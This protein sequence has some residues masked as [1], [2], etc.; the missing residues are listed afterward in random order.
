MFIPDSCGYLLTTHFLGGF[1]YRFGR[2]KV[3]IV[4]MIILGIS[5][6]LVQL[7]HFIYIYTFPIFDEFTIKVPLVKSI[8]Y[9]SGPHFGIGAGIGAVD[10][11]LVP[12]LATLADVKTESDTAVKGSSYGSTFALGQS[13]VSL[14]YCLG[15]EIFRQLMKSTKM[16]IVRANAGRVSRRVRRFPDT[17]ALNG[18]SQPALLATCLFI[19]TQQ[20][21]GDNRDHTAGNVRDEAR[22]LP[23]I[24]KRG[25]R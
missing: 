20:T 7:P 24:Q 23:S 3:A 14:A 16:K 4:S 6:T 15:N 12:L 8:I 19:E 17:H 9:L 10:A 13:A 11:A 18:Y 5:C 22:Q 1:A 25:I 21:I 2:W